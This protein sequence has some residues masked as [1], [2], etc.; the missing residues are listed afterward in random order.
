MQFRF[1]FDKTVQAA[2]VLLD[3]DGDRMEY[4]R[5]L[6]LLYIT[7]RELLAETGRTLTGDRVVAMKNGPV[8]SHIYDTIQGQTVQADRWSVFIH[9]QGYQVALQLKPGREK[10]SKR[11][12]AKLLDVT[13]RFRQLENFELSEETHKFQ[14]WQ[15][16]YREGT[17]TPIPWEDVLLAQGKPEMVAVA[18]KE[19]ATRA[20]LHAFFRG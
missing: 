15:R 5:L 14:E 7:D 9:R 20:A 17:A 4:M 18:Q 6:K 11:E 3:A 13:E 16:Y 10:L 2:G 19:T 12:I 8:L 1:D